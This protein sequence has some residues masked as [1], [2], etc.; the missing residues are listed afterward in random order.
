[1]DLDVLQA[2]VAM[3]LGHREAEMAE[4]FRNPDAL[5]AQILRDCTEFIAGIGGYTPPL[6]SV[7]R[8]LWI[9]DKMRHDPYFAARV[10]AATNLVHEYVYVAKE[11]G[12]K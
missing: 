12:S 6:D 9:E 3:A 11:K 10:R 8:R 2:Q 7:A 5:A 4:A 1:M